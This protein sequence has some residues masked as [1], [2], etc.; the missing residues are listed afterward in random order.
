M[1]DIGRLGPIVEQ[2]LES[3]K[4][5]EDERMAVDLTFRAAADL[6]LIRHSEIAREFY[7]RRDIQ[8]RTAT[9]LEKWLADNSDAA[10][11]TVTAICGR[12]HVASMGGNGK[13][14]LT[15]ILDQ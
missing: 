15:P 10:P 13:L 8:E 1:S 6:A 14:Q 7:A 3:G 4:L 5:T 2:L 12:L 11:G 9:T